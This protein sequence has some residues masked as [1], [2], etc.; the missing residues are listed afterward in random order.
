MLFLILAF[1]VLVIWLLSTLLGFLAGMPLHILL[2]VA[3]IV[4]VVWLVARA[5]DRAETIPGIP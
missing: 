1:I 3:A 2:V 4:F 5:G